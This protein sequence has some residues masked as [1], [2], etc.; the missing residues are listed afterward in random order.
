MIPVRLTRPYPHWLPAALVAGLA[1]AL[2]VRWSSALLALAAAALALAALAVEPRTRLP[3]LCLAVLVGGCW[4]GSV[5]LESLDASELAGQ[6]GRR[7]GAEVVVTGPVRRGSFELRVP[8]RVRRFGVLEVDE[9]VLLKLPPG[10]A[11]PQ[12]AVLRLRGRLEAPRG[13]D[14]G[15]DERGWLR[16]Q[17]VHVV[18]HGGDWR[19][20]GRRR[21]V[22]AISDRLRSWVMG[23]LAPGLRG[24]RRAVIAGI[25][26]GADEGLPRKLRED[27]RAAGLYHLLGWHD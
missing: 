7:R 24:E 1:G 6:I 16:R 23:S 9:P 19:M 17:G 3:A 22:A 26:L 27:F 2:V 13:P 25:V 10:R 4:W 15:F 14:D 20:V 21:G 18:L 11:P 12:G 8:A 5:R